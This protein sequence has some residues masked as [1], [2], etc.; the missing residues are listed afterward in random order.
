MS[1]L[2]RTKLEYNA[3]SKT[4][5]C[6]Y[7]YKHHQFMGSAKCHEDD[8]DFSSELIGLDLAEQRA[9]LEYLK[10]KRDEL[11][12]R[13]QTL[14][15]FYEQLKADKNFDV[16]STYS[17]KMAAEIV[18]CHYELVDCRMAIREIPKRMD[19]KIK[20]REDLYQKLRKARK[21]KKDNK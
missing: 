19:A 5:V 1:K 18:Y 21:E 20:G 14:K 7:Q 2:K 11:A 17:R 8:Y 3:E 15:G 6:K 12:I 10:V 9:Y 16:N 4:A 13:Y